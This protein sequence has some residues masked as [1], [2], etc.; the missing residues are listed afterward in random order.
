M[1]FLVFVGLLFALLCS[2]LTQEFGLNLAFMA[3]G[4]LLTVY[5]VDAAVK[6]REK[7][8]WSEVD[9]IAQRFLRRAATEYLSSITYIFDPSGSDQYMITGFEMR[10]E[11]EL[12]HL[13][14]AR[15]PSWRAY[16]ADEIAPQTRGFGFDR[17]Q[18]QHDDL[19]QSLTGY[20]FRL[21]QLW[22]LMS[23][24]WSPTQLK[25]VLELVFELPT[26]INLLRLHM[27]PGVNVRPASLQSIVDRSLRL[28]DLCNVEDAPSK[29]L[30]PYD[31]GYPG[32][33]ESTA[34]GQT[35]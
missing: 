11:P 6:R 3:I 34:E 21:V 23:S 15:D 31:P 33:T 19:I 27:K 24:R 2:G 28:I 16:I 14:H 26:E 12:C 29:Y 18:G 17:F 22:P 8:R 35:S 4:V 32:F 13:K 20:H 25:E 10:V 5:L 1:V 30:L 7:K 9:D